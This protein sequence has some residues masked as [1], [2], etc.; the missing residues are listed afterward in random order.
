MV[1]VL[2]LL[3]HH[4]VT[5]SDTS[6]LQ[7]FSSFRKKGSDDR[8]PTLRAGSTF[9]V[10]LGTTTSRVTTFES[11]QSDS[12]ISKLPSRRDSARGSVTSLESR[13]GNEPDSG[14]LG[15]SV[16][17]TP[18]NGHK[19]DIIFVHGLGGTSRWTWSKNKDPELFWPLTFLALE[20]DVCLARIMTFGYNSAFHKAGDG[21]TS[22]LDFAENLLH[23]LKFSEDNEGNNL[24]IGAVSDACL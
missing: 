18:N 21:K 16:V 23:D 4:N 11:V 19:A 12:N 1:R 5:D 15:L 3:K 2:L 20:A 13:S 24:N 22:V 8:T 17:Y 7:K 9:N 6:Q 10:N 14:P